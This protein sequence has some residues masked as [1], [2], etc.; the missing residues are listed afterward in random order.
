M[1]F[2]K[3][4]ELMRDTELDAW[5]QTLPQQIESGLCNDTYGKLSGWKAALEELPK[6]NSHK[7]ELNS[8]QVSVKS[9]KAVLKT[10]QTRC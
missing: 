1:N 10:E 6:I 8:T 3:L 2:N 5:L 7:V 9:E 4:F